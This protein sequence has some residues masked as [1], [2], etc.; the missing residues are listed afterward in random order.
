MKEYSRTYPDGN[1]YMRNL[2]LN[3]A[4]L[5]SRWWQMRSTNCHDPS[6]T[7]TDIGSTTAS[8]VT[9]QVEHILPVRSSTSY[10]ARPSRCTRRVANADLYTQLFVLSRFSA[11]AANGRQ[12]RQVVVRGTNNAVPDGPVTRTS[13]VSEAFWRNVWNNDEALP[14]GLPRVSSSSPDLRNPAQR[15]YERMGS[16]TNP[17]HF[18]FLRDSV[19]AVKGQLET[20]KRPMAEAKIAVHTMNALD[21]TNENQWLDIQ[22]VFSSLRE[23]SPL[24]SPSDANSHSTN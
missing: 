14:S 7:A 11:V 10:H 8:P 9:G 24:F 12:F 3:L 6:V 18:V 15:L 23:V 21:A 1:Q 13:Q 17:T 16:N 22:A 2:R 19:N 5:S 20:F 4:N